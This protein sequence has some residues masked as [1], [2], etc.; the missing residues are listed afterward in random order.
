LSSLN[1]HYVANLKESPQDFTTSTA[2]LL[3]HGILS[4][5]RRDSS[6][7]ERGLEL[8]R[9]GTALID[10]YKRELSD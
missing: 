1:W 10:R 8:I 2:D 7:L 6:P 5:D 3:L 4:I 9:E